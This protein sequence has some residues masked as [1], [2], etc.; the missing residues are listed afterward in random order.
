MYAGVEFLVKGCDKSK[1][2]VPR[3]LVY[4]YP[5][6]EGEKRV[7]RVVEVDDQATVSENLQ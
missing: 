5:N 3:H 7:P 4:S 1:Y 6:E 2:K